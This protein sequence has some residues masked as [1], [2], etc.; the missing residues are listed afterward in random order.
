MLRVFWSNILLF[1]I[2]FFILYE[3]AFVA[4]VVGSGIKLV[5]DFL[6]LIA[7]LLIL[8]HLTRRLKIR[9]AILNSPLMYFILVFFASAV[10]NMVDLDVV[11]V[12]LR[13]YLLMIGLYYLIVFKNLTN[14]DLLKI[15]KIIC[16]FSIPIIASAY[17][18]YYTGRNLI[19]EFDRYGIAFSEKD[20]RRVYTLIGNPI[21]YANYIAL[22]SIIFISSLS[23]KLKLFNF[24]KFSSV[25]LL[26][27]IIVSLFFANSRGAVIA[28]IGTILF[29]A[30]YLNLISKARV[31]IYIL[32]AIV[33]M[34]V[35]EV[36]FISRLLQF[37]FE[38]FE[39]DKYRI[40]FLIKSIEVFLDNPFI[41]VG[42][43]R[44]G[45]WVS[46]NYS[47]SDIYTMYNFTTDKISSIDMFF[48]HLIGEL[49]LLGFWAYLMFFIKPF[50]CY[51]KVLKREYS[52]VARF[53][54]LIPVLMI[55]MLFLMGWF[56]ISLE[57]QV[58]FG[59]YMLLLGI[60]EKYLEN[61]NIR[62]TI[63][64]K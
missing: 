38:A 5:D 57:T 14:S 10:I 28:L 41:G 64:G 25:A 31:L 13:S 56:S 58:I 33:F 23:S 36:N 40:L 39:N 21:D 62:R 20:I 34:I 35:F 49:G 63:S 48:P 26:L 59:M 44:F 45:G 7:I 50:L 12:Q 46:I 4:F 53:F 17:I 16:I 29:A 60:S 1:S 8:L 18:E 42:P 54:S 2:L 30:L 37:N 19:V 43:G 6:S 3:K 22:I 9:Y 55:P 15:V 51:L 47:E 24:S 61:E 52:K 32:L 27:L 11:L